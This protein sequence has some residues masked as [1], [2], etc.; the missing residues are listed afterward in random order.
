MITSQSIHRNRIIFV[1]S[2]ELRRILAPFAMIINN[3]AEMKQK[4]WSF[5]AIGP[6]LYQPGHRL[7]HLSLE[8][9]VPETPRI[10]YHV[11]L[12]KLARSEEHT[13]ELQSLMRITYAVFCLKK[14]NPNNTRLNYTHI[15]RYLQY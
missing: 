2:K 15:N 10:T 5:L 8:L 11:K 4:P 12:H 9:R 1:G 13:S 7:R 3:I 6:I 14:K